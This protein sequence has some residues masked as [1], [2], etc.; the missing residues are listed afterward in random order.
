MPSP[1]GDTPGSRYKEI[2]IYARP[3]RR[4]PSETSSPPRGRCAGRFPA[5]TTYSWCCPDI[6]LLLS[7]C[8][9][10]R[11]KRSISHFLIGSS[12]FSKKVPEIVAPQGLSSDAGSPRVGWTCVGRAPQSGLR[13][14]TVHR[15][16][17]I[18]EL[19]LC[20]QLLI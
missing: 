10:F 17:I 7:R 2:R 19:L 16:E 11:A 18:P 14:C 5:V 6:V 15:P 9:G 3:P 8:G 4:V 13:P 20:S 1:R 12:Q